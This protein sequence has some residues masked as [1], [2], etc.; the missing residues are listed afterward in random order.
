[1]KTKVLGALL[2]ITLMPITPFVVLIASVFVG[3]N[4]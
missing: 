1:M 3:S 2:F 4:I